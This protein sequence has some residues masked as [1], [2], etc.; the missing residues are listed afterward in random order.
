[1]CQTFFPSGI[2]KMQRRPL[3]PVTPG[4]VDAEDTGI[5]LDDLVDLLL[6]DTDDDDFLEGLMDTFTTGQLE[7]IASSMDLP[8]PAP[9]PPPPK[10]KKKRTSGVRHT[11]AFKKVRTM[12]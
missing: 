4:R 12:R 6:T 9:P 2:F 7:Q 10:R 3:G 5:L 1:M 8:T 11:D